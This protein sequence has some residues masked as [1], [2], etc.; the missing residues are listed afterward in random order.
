MKKVA[1]FCIAIFIA[2]AIF[3]TDGGYVVKEGDTL[4]QISRETGVSVD[5]LI[6]YNDLSDVNLIIAGQELIVSEYTYEDLNEQLVMAVLWYQTSGEFKALSY[7]AFN[8]ARMLFDD[9]LEAYPDETVTRAVIVDID[10][11]VLNN[12]PWEAG[13]IDTDNTYPHDFIKWCGE[14]A[15]APQPGAAEFLN[16]VVEKGGEVFYI[17]N[18]ENILKKMTM[19]NLKKSGFPNVDNEHVLLSTTTFDKEPRRKIISE[20]Y[21]IVVLMGDNLN[22]FS[23]VFSGKNIEERN[24]SV[25]QMKEYWGTKFVILPNPIYGDWEGAVYNWNWNLNAEEKNET[26]KKHLVVW[27]AK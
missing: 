5:D 7:Q 16:Y 10:E 12:I 26:R 19:D 8:V 9:D 20:K 3:A 13:Q 22:D 6:E 23:S 4:F 2:G 11:T 25:D 17:S 15:A 18:R 24:L 14:R 1:V 27:P 21:R